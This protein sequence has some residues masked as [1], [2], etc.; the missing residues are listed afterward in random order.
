MITKTRPRTLMYVRNRV[1]YKYPNPDTPY[2]SFT[3]TPPFHHSWV[4]TVSGDTNPNW[5]WQVANHVNAGTRLVGNKLEMKPGFYNHRVKYDWAIGNHPGYD[6]GEE[7]YGYYVLTVP[8]FTSSPTPSEAIA[9]NLALT[10]FVSKTRDAQTTFQGGT[11][12]GELGE[13]V[14]MLR[15][16]VQ[17]LRRGLQ[18][19]LA[20]L[21]KRRRVTGSPQARSRARRRILSDTWL[22]YSFGLVPLIG[23]IADAADVLRGAWDI[24]TKNVSGT[25]LHETVSRH[26]VPV[27]FAKSGRP[28]DVHYRVHKV[29]TVK[30]Y[31]QVALEPAR[32]LSTRRLGLDLSNFAPT[33]WNLLPWSF[34]VDYFTNIGDIIS[35][36]SLARDS[37]KWTMKTVRRNMTV[38]PERFICRLSGPTGT[39][40]STTVT[41][42]SPGW[43]VSRYSAIVRDVY[44]GSLVPDFEFQIPGTGTKWLNILALSQSARKLT[45]YY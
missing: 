42:F 24:N 35:A 28:M 26:S 15:N 2:K 23:D 33:A 10:H 19:Y 27:V 17:S 31:G 12:I 41:R 14:R 30:Y 1:E 4:D 13:T 7:V 18:D 22:E 25:G 11:F 8:S 37:L 44:H 5:K 39:L 16:P 20:A 40:G 32:A 43:A 29:I 45:P 3:S 38:R 9:N 34:L 36:A 21:K 6:A